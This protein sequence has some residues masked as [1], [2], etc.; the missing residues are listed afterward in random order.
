MFE[1]P[2]AIAFGTLI[3]SAG[4]TGI[5]AICKYRPGKSDNAQTSPQ[6]GKPSNGN[7]NG[8]TENLCQ[9]RFGS[10]KEDICELRKGQEKIS[11]TQGKIF[12]KIEEVRKEIAK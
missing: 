10:V 7:G 8:V 1:M 4:A 5:T 12:D 3:V 11:E 2:D 9:A 6:P